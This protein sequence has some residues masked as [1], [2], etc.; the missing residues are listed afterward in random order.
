[1]ICNC[2]LI[3]D[4]KLQKRHL[5]AKPHSTSLFTSAELWSTFQI[6]LSNLPPS[7]RR[8][9]LVLELLTEVKLIYLGL[10]LRFEREINFLL[11]KLQENLLQMPW[12][13]SRNVARLPATAGVSRRTVGP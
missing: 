9:I 4:Y 10:G 6:A 11:S 7:C 12:G 8:F 1:M 5:K 3:I 13:M 2:R